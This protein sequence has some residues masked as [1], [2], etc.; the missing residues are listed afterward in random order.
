MGN[1]C[2][3]KADS[4]QCMTKYLGVSL[5]RETKDLYSKKYKTLMKEIKDDTDGEIN[6]R[7]SWKH[8]YCENDYIT[9]NNQTNQFNLCQTNGIFFPSGI[10]LKFYNL[11]GHT[12]DPEEANES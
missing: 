10:E 12:K 1:T 5:L 9:Q 7:L 2:I 3:P 11:Y 8:Q 6:R 4:C